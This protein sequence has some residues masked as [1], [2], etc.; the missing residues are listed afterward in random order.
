MRKW[1]YE[2]QLFNFSKTGA[3]NHSVSFKTFMGLR[4]LLF[5]YQL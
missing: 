2:L 4:I 3:E 5:L 1:K